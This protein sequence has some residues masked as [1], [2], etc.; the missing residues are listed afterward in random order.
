METKLSRRTALK[1]AVAGTVADL[2]LRATTAGAT[3]SNN[4]DFVDPWSQAHD[5]V[6]LGGD[7]WANPM[8]DWCIRDGEAECLSI[9]GNRNIQSLTHQLTNPSGSFSMSVIIRRISEG[10][11][12]GGAGFRIGHH[13]E[14]KEYRSNCFVSN[15]LRA[16]I[17]DRVLV[18]GA[19]SL[20]LADQ[21]DM[22]NIR[23]QLSGRPAG[24]QINLVLEALTPDTGN[25]LGKIVQ[26]LPHEMLM[27]NVA[28]VSNFT[29]SD[30][31]PDVDSKAG[32]LYRFSQWQM[33]GDGFSVNPRQKF[34][35]LL[36][37]MYSLNDSR[38]NDGFILKISALTGPMGKDD[39][40]VVELLVQRNGKWTSLGEA[41]LDR[42]AWVATFRLPNWDEKVA[43]PYR[44]VYR[45]KHRDG[46]ESANEWT[47]TI[48]AN[49]VGR[50][51]R[52]AAL[53]CQNDYAFP[54]EPVVRNLAQLKPDIIFFS[55]DQIYEFNGGYGYIRNPAELSILCY[56]RKFYQFGWAF[57]E[58][59]SS[60][61]TLCLPDDHDVFQGNLWGE[62]GAVA[63][64]QDT[65]P[66]AS[67]VGG[68]YNPARVVNVVHMTNVS[69]H[70]DPYDPTP[71]L[72]DI[73]AYYGD[74][75]YGDVGFAIVADRQWKSGPEAIDVAVGET[76]QGEDPLYVNP[77]YDTPGLSLLG[78]RQEN[79]L[80]QWAADWR[81]HK[82]KALLS[83]TVFA[84]LATHQPTP[85]SYVKVDFDSAGWPH[86]PR[87]HAVEIL[88]PS[89]ALHICGDTHLTTL[90]QYGVQKQ[91]D[92]IWAFTTPAVAVGWSRWWYPDSMH[93]PHQNRPKHGLPNTG[94]YLD[95]FGNKVY[96]YAVGNPVVGISSNRY[97]LAD[98]KG[99]GFGFITFD[100][101][102]L[103]YT[104]D[105]YRFLVDVMDGKPGN[106]F[107][108]WPV[109][110]H[111][112]E[113]RG[114]NQ[115]A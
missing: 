52:M 31:R 10:T 61:P 17:I 53:T 21:A 103:T 16:G 86:T 49:P 54:Y 70:P 64:H 113:N 75:V 34:G 66:G 96:V 105:S 43:T 14:I 111:Q 114:E 3:T 67:L 78:K 57:R 8:E 32:S 72:Q 30:A 84:G 24:S 115:V 99:S 102:K 95:T 71:S 40:Q 56:L 82:L 73:S 20:V 90:A 85:S 38:T 101:G 109:T 22:K 77:A 108:G 13:T 4:A 26:T 36:W 68:Y 7:F 12:D 93:M 89:M 91:R 46:S 60:C 6:W 48:Q 15:G 63:L 28:L 112:V 65:D 23:L 33:S 27:G 35:P 41:K 5:R 107:P 87:D 19:K 1:M 97:L 106:Q 58:V 47:G 94:E 98:Q 18:L 55:G 29:S 42:D 44:L 88:R 62:G 39:N 80:K 83:Q 104:L 9:G 50:P 100:T 11:M 74:M 25:S 37:S 59:M 110:I 92:S 76:G 2:G 81:G 79:F 69:H 51:L 45:E